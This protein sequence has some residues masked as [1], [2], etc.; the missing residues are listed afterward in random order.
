MNIAV[1]TFGRLKADRDKPEVAEFANAVP[2]VFA[3]AE[4]S[5]GFVW[6]ADASISAEAQADRDAYSTEADVAV[7]LSVWQDVE[8]LRHYVYNTLHGR[9]YRRKS[10]WFLPPGQPMMVLWNVEEDVRPTFAEA[11]ERLDHLRQHGPSA[12][13]FDWD[14][15]ADF[16]KR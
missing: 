9:F 6:R 13:A 15:A 2:S 7:T 10:E 1:H 16:E 5:E 11:R 14:T 12:F 4:R 8:R 3:L